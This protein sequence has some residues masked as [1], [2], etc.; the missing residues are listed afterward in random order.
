MKL[1]ISEKEIAAKRIAGILSGN[2]QKE[3]K[4]YGV[5]VYYIKLGSDECAVIG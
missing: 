4:V 2:G 3:E 1:I 5:P